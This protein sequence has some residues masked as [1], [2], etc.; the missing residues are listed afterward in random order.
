ML[1]EALV[2]A[3]RLRFL[4]ADVPVGAYLSGGIDSSVTAAI[5]ARYTR[6]PL[7]TFSLRFTDPEFDEGPFQAE[8]SSR[9][10]TAH[11]SVAVSAADIGGVFP[12][13]IWHA[14][15]P[16]LRRRPP[17][18]FSSLGWCGRRDSRSS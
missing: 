10:G 15:R 6:V 14:E 9:I 8:L 18:Y 5:I 3:T 11:R 13:V 17:L 12:E 16:V 7:T 2:E 1:R 4:R